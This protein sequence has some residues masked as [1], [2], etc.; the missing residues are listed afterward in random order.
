MPCHPVLCHAVRQTLV[1]I[2]ERVPNAIDLPR[3]ECLLRHGRKDLLKRFESRF[4]KEYEQ[5]VFY[6]R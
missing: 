6:G 2:I 3:Q 5:H 4:V 1:S